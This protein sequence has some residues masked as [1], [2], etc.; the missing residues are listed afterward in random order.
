MNK[1]I[2]QS[3]TLS[4]RIST[5]GFCFCTYL[6]QQP[7][8]VRYTTYDCD[9]QISITANFEAAW[10]AGNLADGKYSK[11]QAIVASTEFTAVPPQVTTRE[12][13]ETIFRSCFPHTKEEKRIISNR[14]S[15]Q[16]MTILFA[17][18]EEL[19]KLLTDIGEVSY[20]SPISIMSGFLTR[21]KVES[22]RYIMADIQDETMHLIA[23]EEETPL[24][25]NSFNANG[26][27]DQLYYLLCIWNELG[28]S[29]EEEPLLLCGNHQADKFEM[30]AKDFI[31]N[32]KRINPRQL[33]QSNLLNKIETTPF[34]LQALILCE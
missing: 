5:D 3:P 9:R 27:A 16:S 12:E 30:S 24:L 20:Y 6:P 4:I 31:R 29:Q 2:Q 23:M 8:S 33:F 1:E 17:I 10:K 11:I 26:T 15:A 7:D 28:F 25:M 13:Q 18:D 22:G 21:Y 14:L 32:I 19:H 34:D